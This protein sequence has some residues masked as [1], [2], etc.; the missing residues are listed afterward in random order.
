MSM[1]VVTMAEGKKVANKDEIIELYNTE[2]IFSCV[3]YLLSVDKIDLESIVNYDLAPVPTS[4]FKDNGEPRFSTT[5][6]VFKNK[7]KV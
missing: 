2:L 6:S 3:M 4:M 5:K 1:K 7:L